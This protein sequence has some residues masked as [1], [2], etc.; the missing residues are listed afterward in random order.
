MLAG[1][2]STMAT[3]QPAEATMAAPAAT[4]WPSRRPSD[5]GAAARYTSANAGTTSSA[6][7][8]LARKPK[9]TSAPARTSQRVAPS[10]SARTTA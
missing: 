6:W 10:S 4:S 7:S 2:S 5:P 1:V 3:H 9:P 8:C